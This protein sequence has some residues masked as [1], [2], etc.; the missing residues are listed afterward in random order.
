VVD[1]ARALATDEDRATLRQLVIAEIVGGSASSAG[2]LI[3]RCWLT[4]PGT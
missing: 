4:V 1:A 2:E 3:D